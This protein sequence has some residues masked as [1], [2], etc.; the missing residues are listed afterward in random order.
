[1]SFIDY[2]NASDGG[3]GLTKKNLHRLQKLQNNAVR[4]IFQLNG[5]KKWEHIK[6]YIYY[7]KVALSTSGIKDQF[8]NVPTCV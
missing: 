1:M 2:C 3:P 5:K 6:Q 7:Q 8:Q 4:F